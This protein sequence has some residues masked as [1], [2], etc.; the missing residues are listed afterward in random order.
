[1]EKGHNEV[2]DIKQLKCVA[3]S[4]NSKL[5]DNQYLKTNSICTTVKL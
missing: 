2:K 5:P 3:S 4:M 1:M